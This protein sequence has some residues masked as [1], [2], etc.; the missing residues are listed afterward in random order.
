VNRSEAIDDLTS[1]K[2]VLCAFLVR[3]RQQPWRDRKNLDGGS[4]SRFLRGG[5]GRWV[6]RAVYSVG[7][8]Q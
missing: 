2:S 8:V 3:A 1:D 5:L 6:R 7:M 4:P